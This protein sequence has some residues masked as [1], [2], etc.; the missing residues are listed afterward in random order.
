LNNQL[1]FSGFK[2][3]NNAENIVE[4]IKRDIK[5]ERNIIEMDWLQEFSINLFVRNIL[6]I[7]L[8]SAHNDRQS[9]TRSILNAWHNSS[10]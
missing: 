3:G 2:E 4:E 1:K 9:I 10:Q 7:R 6:T 8:H 5:S